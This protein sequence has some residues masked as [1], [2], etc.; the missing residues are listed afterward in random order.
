MSLENGEIPSGLKEH[1]LKVGLVKF[2]S[3]V[4]KQDIKDAVNARLATKWTT[5]RA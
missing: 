3:G 4:K 2:V 1:V 5:T